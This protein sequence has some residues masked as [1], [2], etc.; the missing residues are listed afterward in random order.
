[1]GLNLKW[2]KKKKETKQQEEPP[3]KERFELVDRFG[4]KRRM[5]YN[6]YIILREPVQ[7]QI[8][9]DR[10]EELL[11]KAFADGQSMAS[12]TGEMYAKFNHKDAVSKKELQEAL[13]SAAADLKVF[14]SSD[15]LA[16]LSKRIAEVGIK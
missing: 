16:S 8:D 13:S 5:D 15:I 12:A 14:K 1:V 9:A 3:K 7:Y 10:V 6:P 2:G 4:L 11:Q